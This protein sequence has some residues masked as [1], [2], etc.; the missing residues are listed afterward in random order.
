VK[1]LAR[2]AVVMG[3]LSFNRKVT[4]KKENIHLIN[5]EEK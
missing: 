2:D 1:Q 3:L 5:K 4:A